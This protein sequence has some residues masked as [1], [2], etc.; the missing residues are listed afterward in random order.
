MYV[1]YLC[2]RVANN[3]NRMIQPSYHTS[4]VIDYRPT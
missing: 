2:G 4:C 1:K 3:T